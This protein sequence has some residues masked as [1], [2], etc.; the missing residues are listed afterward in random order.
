MVER[1]NARG[2]SNQRSAAW[3][4]APE[5]P[6]E[7]IEYLNRQLTDRDLRSIPP[8]APR[9]PASDSFRAPS[10][11]ATASAS[12]SLAELLR[13][14][15]AMGRNWQ[16]GGAAAPAWQGATA[17]AW[18]GTTTS[19]WSAPRAAEVEVAV[20]SAVKPRSLG[21][22][23]SLLSGLSTTAS[24]EKQLQMAGGS[25]DAF[26]GSLNSMSP[27]SCGMAVNSPGLGAYLGALSTPGGAISAPADDGDAQGPV[28]YRR[29]ES[30]VDGPRVVA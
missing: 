3:R 16:G 12:T 14:A 27:P 26:L 18:Q 10:P 9:A 15:E 1:G 20:A 28:A 22:D 25:P 29:P 5:R 21:F 4:L 24:P 6:E 7:V 13:R 19:G 17:P 23:L 8:S 11:P 2:R 30:Y